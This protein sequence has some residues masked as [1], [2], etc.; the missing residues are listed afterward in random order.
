MNCKPGRKDN[1]TMFQDEELIRRHPTER[2]SDIARDMGYSYSV[3]TRHAHK[4]GLYKET[5][6]GYK[7]TA[8]EIVKGNFH[9][10]SYR[11]LA[12][13]ADVS[14]QT[15]WEITRELGL[16]RT[17]EQERAVRSRIR[18][19][20]IVKERRRVNWGMEQKTRLKVYSNKKKI[21]LRCR[22]VGKGYIKDE[23]GFTLYYTEDTKR[24]LVCEEHGR[25]MGLRFGP[26]PAVNQEE[27]EYDSASQGMWDV[28]PDELSLA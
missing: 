14:F 17:P 1:W 16:K 3:V 28:Q 12:K 11:E 23:D 13:I 22:L 10:H 9:D 15:V 18:H 26:L 5:K 4:L 19:E 8:R 24:S 2:L 20:L 25:A 6:G 21:N 27:T 7:V